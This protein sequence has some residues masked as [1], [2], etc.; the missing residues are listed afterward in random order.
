MG[1]G[2]RG[3]LAGSVG[4]PQVA[5]MQDGQLEH[6]LG[7]AGILSQPGALTRVVVVPR[8]LWVDPEGGRSHA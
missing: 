3:M 8:W 1:G 7:A 6:G 2:V 4:L 5:V